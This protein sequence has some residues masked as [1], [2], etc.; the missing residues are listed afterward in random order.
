MRGVGEMGFVIGFD[1]PKLGH[2]HGLAKQKR[3]AV[4]LLLE[5]LRQPRDLWARMGA[6]EHRQWKQVA[7]IVADNLIE[8]ARS[9]MA[10]KVVI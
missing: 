1:G 2:Q 7:N 4:A 5:T 10:S 3:E 9:F 8:G 6:E